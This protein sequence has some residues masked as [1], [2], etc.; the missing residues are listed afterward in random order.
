M[1]RLPGR[2]PLSIHPLFWLVSAFIGYFYTPYSFLLVLTWMVV[3]FLSVLVHEYGH[4]ITAL[5]FGKKP[6]ITLTAF[7]GVTTYE[8]SHLSL[9]RQFLIVL[10]GP[11][12][13][14]LLGALAYGLLFLN[15]AFPLLVNNALQYLALVNIFW[16]IVNLLPIL[17]LDGGQLLRIVLEAL[18]GVRG[19]KMAF[20][21]AMVLASSLSAFL[22]LR[23]AYIGGVILFLFAF[24]SYRSWVASKELSSS[25]KDEEL[26]QQL[27]EAEKTLLEG[28]KAA[29]IVAFEEIV[30][31]AKTGM[32]YQ[33]ASQYL[34]LLYYR[35][36]R[37]KEGY[38][39]LYK[40]RR[41]LTKDALYALHDLAFEEEDYVLVTE[42]STEC[43]KE[44]QTVDVALR[45]ARAYGHLGNAKFSGGWLQSAHNL[46]KLPLDAV[47]SETAFKT[48][49]KSA[50]FQKFIRKLR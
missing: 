19:I 39:T 31:R 20:F 25:D 21:I 22:L 38:E 45:N 11:I 6:E 33:T 40:V 15:W 18:F 29:A 1:I 16:T 2:I 14:V 30:E 23:K 17:P 27:F 13:G 7:G 37:K 34:G 32:I 28:K 47:L 8:A 36:G 44:F 10:N 48:V 9:F 46:S 3:I 24:E 4:A 42:L 5:C 43:F 35:E 41:L 50:V 49:E 12:A 26:K